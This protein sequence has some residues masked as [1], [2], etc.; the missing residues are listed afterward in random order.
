MKYKKIYRKI[1]AILPNN[2]VKKIE[3]YYNLAGIK[4]DF[5]KF[6]V[7]IFFY[8]I[9]FSIIAFFL[10]YPLNEILSLT[11]LPIVFFGFQLLILIIL[12]TIADGRANFA[13]E[14]LPDFLQLM[15][16]NIRAGLT[17]D[18]ALIF[19]ARKEFGILEEEIRDVATKSLSGKPFEEALTDLSKKFKSNLI[20]RTVNLIIEGVR[21][22]GEMANLLEQT[23]NDIRDLKMMKKEIASQVNMYL[24]FIFIALG[25]ISPILFAFSSFLLE[26]MVKV[27]QELK[28]EE[29]PPTQFVFFK[30]GKISLDLN[31]FKI[32]I[33]TLNIISSIF[34]SLI[35]GLLSQG[36]EKAGL[37]FIP[38]LIILNLILFFSARIFIENFIKIFI[39]KTL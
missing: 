17:P 20:A 4:V 24:I 23:A 10:I 30:I 5:E 3:L 11:V 36:K 1:R 7:T 8:S 27:T 38:I 14:V 26:T 21:K 9:A 31:F 15:A 2:L 16:S 6:L 19:S 25:V 12:S 32:Y 34:G 37:K 33:F 35:I 13:E 18:K 28:I 39:P 22:G 29:V